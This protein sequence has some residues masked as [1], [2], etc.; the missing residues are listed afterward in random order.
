MAKNESQRDDVLRRMLKT[1]PQRK[2]V[3]RQFWKSER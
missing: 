3:T 1:P 2:S